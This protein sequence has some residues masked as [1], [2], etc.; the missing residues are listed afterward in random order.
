MTGD[1]RVG[2]LVGWNSDGTISGSSSSGSVTGEDYVGGLVGDSSNGTISGSSSSGSVTGDSPVGGLV[3]NFSGSRSG[4]VVSDCYATGDVI[5]EGNNSQAGGLVGRTGW[6]IVLNCYATGD[7]TLIGDNGVAGGLVGS[8][9][10]LLRNGYARGNVEIRGNNGIAGGLVGHSDRAKIRTSYATGNVLVVGG[11]GTAGGL[12]GYNR[13]ERE[14]ATISACYS[15]GQAIASENAGGLIGAIKGGWLRA[16]Y[17]TGSV[18]GE[19]IGGLIGSGDGFVEYSYFDHE[20]S[21]RPKTD[22]YAK[23]SDELHSVGSY[24]GIYEN[25]AF[26][27][28]CDHSSDDIWNFVGDDKYPK[29]KLD[30]NGDLSAT[31]SEFGEQLLVFVDADGREMLSPVLSASSGAT[32]TV[33]TLRGINAEND[34]AAKLALEGM[35]D[36]F[37]LASNGE[38]S[39]QSGKA[40][41]HLDAPY[42]VLVRLTEG[43]R[44]VVRSVSVQVAALNDNDGDG[45]IDVTTLEQLHAIGFDLNG[46]GQV[47][48]G[49]TEADSIAYEGAFGLSRKGSIHCLASCK[50]YELMNNLD[51]E[52]ANGDGT[53]DDKSIWAEGASGAGV[54]GAVAEGWAP[55]GD[56]STDSDESRFT[57][58]FE[59]NDHTISNLYI[60]RSGTSY[61]GLFG[62]L[63]LG[64][65]VRNLGI[66]GGRLSGDGNVGGLVGYSEGTISACYATGTATG[67]GDLVGGLVGNNPGT[68]SAC[69]ATGAASGSSGV[70]G[71]VGRNA[72]TI[73]ACYATGD[74]TGTGGSVGGLVGRNAGT[75]SACYAT[76][77]ATGGGSVGGLVGRNDNSGT[78][79]ACYAT[80]DAS[81]TNWVGGLVG[82]SNGG[83]ISACYATGD[84]SGSSNVGGLVGSSSGTVTNSYFDST[85]SNRTDSDDYAKTTAQ[86]QT[87]TV[88]DDNADATDGS[89]IYE[90]WNIDVDDGQPIGVDDGTMPGDA[91]VDDPWDFGTDSEYPALRADFNVSG[92]PTAFEFGGQGRAAAVPDAPSALTATAANT[93]VT[94]NWDAPSENGG[95]EITGYMIEHDTDMNFPSPT[96]VT[97]ADDA[98]SHTVSSLTNATPYYFRVA[99][100]NSVGTGA[101]YPGATDAAVTATPAPEA[102]AAPSALTAMAG[103]AEV[104]LNWTAAASDGGATITGYMVEYDTDMNFPSPTPAT[105]MAAATSHTVSGLANGT[106]YYFRVAAVN[107]VGA[108]AYYPG[109]GDAAVSA[110]PATVPAAPSALTAMAG[111]AEVTLNWTAAASDGGATITGYMV[112]YDT[113]MN[114]SS[115]PTPATTAAAATS[116]TVSGL[117]NG[118]PYYF[119]VAAVN[120]VGTSA[121]YPGASGT[122]VSAT[123]A[124]V[125]AAPSALTATAADAA[126]TL[127]WTAAASDGG[128]TI[129]GYMVEYDTDMNFPSPTPATTAAAATSHTVSGLTNGTL[130]YFRVAAVNAVGTGAYYPGATD[131]AVS[132]AP[133]PP[134]PVVLSFTPEMGVVGATVMITG[135]GFSTTVT[136][137]AV[138][139]L[140][141]E[142]NDA[143][144]A[145]ATVSTS[146]APTATSLSVSVPPAAQTGKISV[147][148]G[149]AADTS[150]A[151]FTVTATTPAPDPPVVSSFTPT[152]GALGATVTITG[153]G[154]STTA[155]ENT[156]TFLGAEA[157]DADNAAATVSISPAPTA[158]SLSVSVPSTAQT[159]KISVMV[160]TAADT[161]AASF[162]V[163][164]TTPAPAAPVVSSFSPTEGEVDTEVT[165]TGVNFS[166]MSSENEV[167]F[168]GVMAED[169]T[170]ASTTSLVVL[171]P[172]GAVT[173]SIS[174]AVG[175]Q[176]GT[177]SEIFTV[178]V[179]AP[180]PAAP[181]VSSFSPTEGEV[182]T[183]VTITG[184]NFSAT[185]SANEVRFGGVMAAAPTSASTT[186]LVVL[187]PSG[188][189]TGRISVAVGGQ[190]GTSSENF[191]VTAPA[192]APAA[193]VV[194]SF[195]PTEGE[196]DTEVTIT[197]VNF[198]DMSSENEVRFGGVMAAAPTSASTTSLAVLVPSG[199]VTGRVSV[200]VGG[201]TGTSSTDFTVTGTTPAPEP[202]V[203]SSFTPT[204]GEV[205]T[206]VTIT[207]E[208]FSD[209][210][211]ENE[212]KFGGVMAAAPTSAS[213]TSLTV[214]VPSGARTGSISVAVGGQ[215]GTSSESFTVT[216][217]APAPEPP[218]VSSFTPSEGVV[219]TSVTI[220]GDNFS[221]TPSENEVRFGGVMAAEP[222][223]ASTTSLT[224]LVPSGARTGSISVAVGGQTGTSSENFTVTAPAP[225]PDPPVVSSFTPTSGPVGTTVTITGENFSDMPSENEVGFGGVMAE[226]PTSAST[227]S[228]TVRVP[229]GARTGR[230]SVAVGG[231]TGTSSED[232]TV[233]GTTP[234]SPFSVPLSSERD[235]RVYPNPTSGQLHFKGL[236]AGGR[237]VCDLYSLV[238]QKVLSSVVRAGD[239]MDTSTLSSGQYILILQAEGR[240]LMRTRLLVVR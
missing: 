142:G 29:L 173:G 76:G 126:V 75:I 68:I 42:T 111:N 100:V 197:G 18:F 215:T 22:A 82:R 105:T 77:D 73:S 229:S 118:T 49:V 152:S 53:A 184:V 86:L 185:P 58:I 61:V 180:A 5:A 35:S 21:N 188:A 88:Y 167:R 187:V 164:A 127:N 157:N 94:L 9:V 146:P 177:S 169:P 81:G 237:Y 67:T 112:E 186:S 36:V 54:S 233:T 170:S 128:A 156:V 176:T 110:T 106:P 33:G 168:G 69:Y 149:T 224:I 150:A 175:G 51:F 153:T 204:E 193:P 71:L 97:T 182:D 131:A 137:N 41:S 91:A 4:I 212:V 235:V 122:A 39:V 210:P 171:V 195:S 56:N 78:I 151:S 135:T 72:G 38:L 143:D 70:G 59:G 219:G 28:D 174:V 119:R 206:S 124:T 55:I 154:F 163:T 48:S 162:T 15:T 80:G 13:G 93:A 95:A 132:A 232:F 62:A 121:Y 52:D 190:T 92:T 236:L 125:P 17:S 202:P 203:V 148:V 183:E 139:F 179:P 165:I 211:S 239:T 189:V 178:T 147:M 3:G 30:F 228:L 120:S 198:S 145:E 231:Q 2:G 99:A 23:S 200:A 141:A 32:G 240:E 10:A 114:F 102:P 123:P 108:S 14:V 225:A 12:V 155:T 44:S 144:N 201:Q 113:D 46:D 208:N 161:S 209:M 192:P 196:V 79:S 1:D 134:P 166:D 109:M 8:H 107:A 89:S 63:G 98:T 216:A 6:A 230:V 37:E 47:D 136:D 11:D 66:E 20:A 130:Y 25:W 234:V 172:S 199:A 64:S 90:A 117:T 214:L 24:T 84:A 60:N 16:C 207:G 85:V 220:T 74:A 213:T 19:N 50:G 115:S 116:H 103:N 104:T 217:P 31:A 140:G 34:N 223:S 194:S 205:G 87:P 159:G 160:G 40:V 57:A 181:V 191:T 158:T 96:P 43:T 129:T 222:T 227:T 238:A 7:V 45:L 218:V 133:T 83:T 138:T 226:D 101:Y 26:D 65:N 27:I 221:A